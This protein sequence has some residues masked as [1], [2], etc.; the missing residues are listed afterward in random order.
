M[1]VMKLASR[2]A[3]RRALSLV[4]AP[5][6]LAAVAL[7]APAAL[8]QQNAADTPQSISPPLPPTK[9]NKPPVI[10]YYLLAA[11]IV[12]LVV[13]VNTIPSKRGHQD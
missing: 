12:F 10:M 2:T 7:S 1:P 4:S 11:A 5:I 9:Q 3:P 8:A 13:G 6:I